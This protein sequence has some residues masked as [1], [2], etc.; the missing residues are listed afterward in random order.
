MSICMRRRKLLRQAGIATIGTIGASSAVAA[1]DEKDGDRERSEDAKTEQ[2]QYHYEELDKET[3][4]EIDQK[5]EAGEIEIGA[6]GQEAPAHWEPEQIST[7]AVLTD[8]EEIFVDFA[9]S[10]NPRPIELNTEMDGSFSNGIVNA[11]WE[12]DGSTEVEL[13]ENT[14]VGGVDPD[15]SI[16][17]SN[18]TPDELQLESVFSIGGVSVSITPSG[19]FQSLSSS[20]VIYE[21]TFTNTSEA[22][23][24]Y[25]GLE[26]SAPGALFNANQSDAATFIWGNESVTL[27]AE[28]N[29]F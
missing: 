14:S 24:Q 8:S 22:S 4:R 3:I 1:A 23:H 20:S 6:V 25:F 18:T 5:I 19:G 21:E 13:N 27:N 16:S 12:S 15:A 17:T 2:G 9:D 11:F 29:K 26:A 28:V 7:Q 10:S